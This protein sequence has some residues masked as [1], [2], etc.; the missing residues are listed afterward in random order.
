[1]TKPTLVKPTTHAP[2]FD[3]QSAGDGYIVCDVR[4]GRPFTEVTDRATALTT[5]DRFNYAATKGRRTLA[6]ELSN[7]PLFG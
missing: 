6:R 7:E 5:R 4:S 1:M 2:A 3:L